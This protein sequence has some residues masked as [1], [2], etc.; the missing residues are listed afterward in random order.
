MSWTVEK[1]AK[2]TGKYEGLRLK[3]YRCTAGKLTIGYGRNL[4][5]RGITFE[6]AEYL[7]M[8]DV[9]RSYQECVNYIDGFLG[10]DEQRQYVLVDMMFN[11]GWTRLSKF[12]NFLSAVK[13]KDWELA[14]NHMTDSKWYQQVGRRA[15]ELVRIMRTGA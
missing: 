11:L 8:N 3:P 12:K 14:G 2:I 6:E 9:E 15:I 7:L 1:Q 5:D 4:D 13:A 10:L